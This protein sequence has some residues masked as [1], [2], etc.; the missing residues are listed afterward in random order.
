MWPSTLVKT[1][2]TGTVKHPQNGDGPLDTGIWRR[3]ETPSRR[4]TNVQAFRSTLL[5]HYTILRSSSEDGSVSLYWGEM[6]SI[7]NFSRVFRY[8]RVRRPPSGDRRDHR[9]VSHLKDPSR[10]LQWA[11]VSATEGL[12]A[13]GAASEIENGGFRPRRGASQWGSGDKCNRVPPS[14]RSIQHIRER[15]WGVNAIFD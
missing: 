7:A 2:I 9:I 1:P 11:R 15:K 12:S 13:I 10:Q 4:A 6:P 14:A 8:A 3:F 5:G